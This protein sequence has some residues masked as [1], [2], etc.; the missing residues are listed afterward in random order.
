LKW[1]IFGDVHGNLISL[2]KLLKIEKNN[3]DRIVCHGDLV[4]YGPWSNECVQLVKSLNNAICLKGNHEDAFIKGFY[5]GN[6]LLVQEFFTICHETF[7]ESKLLQEYE[8]TYQISS[9]SVKHTIYDKYIFLDTPL[10]SSKILE[11]Y[12]IGHS[13]QQFKRVVNSFQIVN[14]GSLGQNR[15]YINLSEYLIFDDKAQVI[16]LKNFVHDI[17]LLID[18]MKIRKYSQNCIDYYNNKNRIVK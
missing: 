17:D 15:K 2:E 13:H 4:N 11:N 14:T 3:Y 6:N 1:L 7:G 12:I 10:E 18:E 5:P 9:F 16:Q 8:T